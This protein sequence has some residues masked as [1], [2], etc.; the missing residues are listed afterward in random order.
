MPMIDGKLYLTI[1]LMFVVI[2]PAS[3]AQRALLIGVGNY[4]ANSGWHRISSENDIALLKQVM[5]KNYIVSTLENQNATKSGIVNAFNKLIKES[6]PGDTVFIHFSCHGQQVLSNKKD[7][8]DHLDEAIVP[9]DAYAKE[10][11]SYHGENHLLDDDLGQMV[12]TL[13]EK[14]GSSGLVIITVDACYSDSMNKGV[15]I[16]DKTIYRGGAGIFGTE[17][18]ADDSLAILQE[19]RTKIDSIGVMD[20]PGASDVIFISACKSFQKNMEIVEDGKGYGS[21]SFAI[22]EAFRK[23]NSPKADI[24]EWVNSILSVMGNR[25]YTQDPQIRSTIPCLPPSSDPEGECG[26]EDGGNDS[27][28]LATLSLVALFVISLILGLIIWKKRK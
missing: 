2:F 11:Q 8:P 3:S 12:T 25:A 13:R 9:Y 23:G 18:I 17:S 5:G 16:T 24:F 4:P 14:I 6:F 15:T 26:E 21:L 7:E 19:N 20:I 28:G 27:K 22:Y 10:S 1:L